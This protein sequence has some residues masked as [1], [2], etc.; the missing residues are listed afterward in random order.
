MTELHAI[1]KAQK[2]ATVDSLAA[3]LGALGVRP[4]RVLLVHS[5]LSALGWVCGAAQA[6]VEALMRVVTD[7]GTLVMPAHTSDNSEPGHWRDPP[8]PPGWHGVIRAN[9]PPFDR[10]LT[11]TRGMGRIAE[12]FRTAPGVL[13]SDHPAVSFCA[14][15]RHAHAV[16]A[17]HR[18]DGGFGEASPL[19]RVYDLDGSLLLLGVG[20]DSNSSLH[21]AE[22]RADW[23]KS[24]LNDGAAVQAGDGARQ[25]VE[26]EDLKHN[27]EDFAE[28][29]RDFVRSGKVRIGSVACGE[30]QLMSQRDLVDFAAAWMSRNRK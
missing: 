16:T 29:G 28:I 9:M 5:S 19:A 22:H 11:P 13:R 3:D 24:M 6:V 10:R 8:V 26:F 17:G 1:T 15:G 7:A 4:C 21:L 2:P 25:W 23:P 12:L 27:S 18:L 20:H 14:W 30:A